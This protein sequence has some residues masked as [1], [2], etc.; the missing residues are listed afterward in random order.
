[1][2]AHAGVA[3]F[4]NKV[5]IS[6]GRD[7]SGSYLLSWDA[8]TIVY[9]SAYMLTLYDDQ[10]HTLPPMGSP[11]SHHGFVTYRGA[12]WAIGGTDGVSS[13]DTVESFDPIKKKWFK[14]PNLQQERSGSAVTV[15]DNTIWVIGGRNSNND[16]LSSVEVYDQKEKKWNYSTNIPK[17]LLLS[18]AVSNMGQLFVVGGV[19]GTKGNLTAEAAIYR[20]DNIARSWKYWNKMKEPRLNHSVTRYGECIQICGGHG[21]VKGI[22]THVS[23]AIN[24]KVNS[25]D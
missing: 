12:L 15:H 13:L 6:G 10:I 1:M 5:Y 19:T 3:T 20:W 9:N 14:R 7:S 23:T 2:T 8:K 21:L 22:P 25:N 16:I 17:P 11:R 4:G 18:A 24:F